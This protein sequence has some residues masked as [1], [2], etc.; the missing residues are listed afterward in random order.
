MANAFALPDGVPP[1]L[2][3]LL[4]V[5]SAKRRGIQ[6][7]W[8]GDFSP[9]DLKPW[10]A[11]LAL[12]E[13]VPETQYRFRVCGTA[14]IP[15]F[16]C[17]ATN[18]AVNDLDGA[19]RIDL[20]ARLDRAVASQVPVLARFGLISASDTVEFAELILP[21]LVGEAGVGM[22]FLAAYPIPRAASLCS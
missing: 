17:D 11:N 20:S 9:R 5:W 21:L 4:A 19:F 22:L 15:R 2:A 7:P 13:R 18:Q 3:G 16:G 8:R 10:L 14:L 6:P 12:L 1:K